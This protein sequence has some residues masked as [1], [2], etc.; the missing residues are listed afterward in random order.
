MP[1]TPPTEAEYFA[2]LCAEKKRQASVHPPLTDVDYA[3]QL[4]I[5]Y[6]E[7][8]RYISGMGYLT[9]EGGRWHRD[10]DALQVTSFAKQHAQTILTNAMARQDVS[11]I[12][13]AQR[14]SSERAIRSAISLMRSDPRILTA[15][16]DLN[17]NPMLFN[18]QNGTLDLRTGELLPHR[19]EDLITQI[20]P[21]TFDPDASCPRWREFIDRI[22]ADGYMGKARPELAALLQRIAGYLLTGDC[23]EQVVF[24]FLGDGANGKTTWVEVM[25]ALLGEY[26]TTTS[27]ETFMRTRSDQHPAA[28]ADLAGS[29][30]VYC[31][32]LAED[33]RINEERLKAM[34]GEERRKARFMHQN[35]FEFIPKFKILFGTN[36]LPE[37]RTTDRATWRR[38]IPIP[39]SVIIPKHV[40][41]RQ[42]KNKLCAELPGILNWALEGCLMWQGMRLTPELVPSVDNLRVAYH[43]EEDHVNQILEDYCEFGEGVWVTANALYRVYRDAC[44]NIGVTPLSANLFGRRLKRRF[45]PWVNVQTRCWQGLRLREG[46]EIPGYAEV[47]PISG[48][49]ETTEDE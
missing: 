26:A 15:S 48:E 3:E 7:N 24:F 16:T 27:S 17:A 31:G 9:Y 21:V 29:R 36:H 23:S 41:D 42:I 32:E 30:F 47:I 19:R 37:V 35:F 14:C 38:I 10:P 2:A 4:A 40:R 8:I 25:S 49:F 44:K 20:A 6:G 43:T 28:I 13:L 18:T 11:A 34:T 1:V 5:C 33:A 22:C 12:R 46:V 45:I 39:F